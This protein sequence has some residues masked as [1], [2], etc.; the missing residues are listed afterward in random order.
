MVGDRVTYKFGRLGDPRTL[1]ARVSRIEEI[2][3]GHRIAFEL[4]GIDADVK[5]ENLDDLFANPQA[6]APFALI[7]VVSTL[8]RLE[9]MAQAPIE[10]GAWIEIALL[11]RKKGAGPFAF[12]A[13]LGPEGYT[14]QF[15]ANVGDIGVLSGPDDPVRPIVD[16]GASARSTVKLAIAA[17]AKSLPPATPAVK[18]ATLSKLIARLVKDTT[19]VLVRDVG[20]ASFCTLKNGSGRTLAHFDAGWP[21]AFNGRTAPKQ[22]PLVQAAPVIL[23]HWDWDHL[24]AYHSLPELRGCEWIAP[25]QHIGPGAM[26]VATTLH[27]G[28]R[29]LV[30]ASHKP[31]ITPRGGLYVGTGTTMNDSGLALF[32]SLNG[33]VRDTLL[34]GDAS[35]AMLRPSI[36][37]STT[38]YMVGTHH[39][40]KF[41]GRLPRRVP[42]LGTC[43]F[44]VGKGNNYKHPRKETIA[45]HSRAGWDI[46]YTGDF[47]GGRRG[48]KSLP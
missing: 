36:F 39:G 31:L 22:R 37:M 43:V 33:Q 21:L 19:Q 41:S 30:H 44:S 32:L 45:T 17:K 5:P 35:Y 3:E 20:Q 38:A 28:G 2:G 26:K 23:S 48:D 15:A 12:V 42:N 29:L 27:A 8:K 16:L 18:V 13:Q 40:G 46:L 7:R 1:V 47:G 10:E 4:D 14:S 34:V 6:T 24:H 9:D 11:P 25:N